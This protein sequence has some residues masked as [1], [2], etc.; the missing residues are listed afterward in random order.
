M[1]VDEARGRIFVT[2]WYNAQIFVVHRARFVLERSLATASAPSGIAI[3]HDGAFLASADRDGNIVSV[4][5][6]ESLEKHGEVTVGERPFGLT[7]SD[8]GLIYVTNVGSNSVSVVD[9]NALKI[10]ATIPT[11]ERPYGVAF[12]GGKGFVTDQYADQITVFD[13]ASA[14]PIGELDSG[15][16]PEGIDRNGAQTE[17]YVANW[18]SNTLAVIDAKSLELIDEIRVGDGPRAFGLFVAEGS[19]ESCDDPL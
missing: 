17:I 7:F 16:Y 9:P 5:D 14:Q 19:T 8:D 12:A 13:E 4:F 3:S 10:T 6:A 2:D 15:E 18:F 1:A 11:G